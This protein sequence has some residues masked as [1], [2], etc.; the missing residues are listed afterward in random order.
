MKKKGK[1]TANGIAL[2]RDSA[3]KKAK[4]SMPKGAKKEGKYCEK[5]KPS[6]GR[7]NNINGIN[8]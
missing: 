7:G 1:M 5:H 8:C 4:A 3:A 6:F 2:D